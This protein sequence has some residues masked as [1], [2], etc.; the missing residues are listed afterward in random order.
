M[1]RR[2][3]REDTQ[4]WYRQFWPWFL[5]LLP[6]SVVVA[7][8]TTVYIAHEGADDLVVDEYYKEGLAINR[9]LAKRERAESLGI[10]AIPSFD[11]LDA[12]VTVVSAGGAPELSLR[13]SHPLEA[14]RDFAI[15]L[16]EASPGDYRGR[17]SHPVA[18]RWHWT[19]ELP[20]EQGK[21]W[22][23]DGSVTAAN[24]SD[25]QRP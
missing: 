14:D 17:L 6:G 23:L 21:G 24:L 4:P 18:E 10:S 11:G 15:T 20:S 1:N 12:Q 9:Q 25:D 5:I 7:A 22:R 3:P 8:L 2:L 13:M 16:V 19:L